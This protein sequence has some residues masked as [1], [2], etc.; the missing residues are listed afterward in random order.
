M[1]KVMKRALGRDLDLIASHFDQDPEAD[2]SRHANPL[3][4][5]GWW[6]VIVTPALSCEG[7]LHIRGAT[8]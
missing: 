5:V 7:F 3:A 8:R 1:M 6:P 2:I 4:A